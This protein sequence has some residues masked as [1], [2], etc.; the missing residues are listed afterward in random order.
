MFSASFR[1]AFERNITGPPL[2]SQTG[3]SGSVDQTVTSV[4]V[5]SPPPTETHFTPIPSVVEEQ[6]PSAFVLE[7][8]PPLRT[9]KSGQE[10]LAEIID[11]LSDQKDFDTYSQQFLS[12][13]SRINMDSEETSPSHLPTVSLKHDSHGGLVEGEKFSGEHRASPPTMQQSPSEDRFHEEL[14]KQFD[15]VQQHHEDVKREF[16]SHYTPVENV[17]P[18]SSDNNDFVKLEKPSDLLDFSPLVEESKLVEKVEKFKPTMSEE[19]VITPSDD[20][21]VP[22]GEDLRD[23]GNSGIREKS[24]AETFEDFMAESKELEDKQAGITYKSL[25]DEINKHLNLEPDL[26]EEEEEEEE[27][28]H[29]LIVFF[30]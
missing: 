1:D 21:A 7:Q 22:Y 25:T 30:L 29:V 11:R 23:F 17:S 8:L 2:Q 27:F 26:P 24:P 5:E 18:Q 13:Y 12:V 14:M 19:A 4:A 16:D 9:D 28:F 10:I 15:Q 3:A 20:V 6:L